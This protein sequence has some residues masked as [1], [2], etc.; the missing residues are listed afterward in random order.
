MLTSVTSKIERRPVYVA[1][2]NAA[3]AEAVAAAKFARGGADLFRS[4]LNHHT[5]GRPLFRCTVS[6]SGHVN[7]T[8]VN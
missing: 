4:S 2:R 5:T 1:A 3:E 8:R 6:P 7:A